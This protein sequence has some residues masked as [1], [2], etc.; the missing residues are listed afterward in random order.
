MRVQEEQ[1]GVWLNGPAGTIE[2]L[3]R[4]HSAG[5]FLL[6]HLIISGVAMTGLSELDWQRSIA[7]Y[8][9]YAAARWA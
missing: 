7:I 6:S 2:A 8:Q 4:Q 3:C 9:T 5:D 1:T